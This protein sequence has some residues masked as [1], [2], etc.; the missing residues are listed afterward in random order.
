MIQLLIQVESLP[1]THVLMKA[2]S[3]LGLSS[4]KSQIS[5]LGAFIAITFIFKNIY[6][7]GYYTIQHKILK[8]WKNEF[9]QRLMKG[10][11]HLPYDKLLGY[12]SA[13]ILRN[14]NSTV[15][16]A[17]NGFILSSFNFI[18]NL[19]TG[20]IILSLVYLK[21]SGPT[22]VVALI[23]ILA[24]ITQNVFLKRLLERSARRRLN[25]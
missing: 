14:I 12:S 19:L 18:T 16:S 3:F 7:L 11:L 21:Y 6:I 22:S 20:A 13:E 15:S 23:L 24:T 8:K 2:F 5:T 17:L 4:T 9:S 1:N 25:F 10:Y